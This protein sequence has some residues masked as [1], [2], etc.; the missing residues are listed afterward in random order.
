MLR[1]E[2]ADTLSRG[3]AAPVLLPGP[4]TDRLIV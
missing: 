4:D 1:S 3:I 2:I